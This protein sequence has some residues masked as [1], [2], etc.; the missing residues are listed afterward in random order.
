MTIQ[1]KSKLFLISVAANALMLIMLCGI[2]YYKRASFVRLYDK[3]FAKSQVNEQELKAFNT[4][5][6]DG[7]SNY[8][9]VEG[10]G[11]LKYSF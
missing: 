7:V 2:G 10:G 4:V 3:H 9:T 8:Y 11:S 1:N 5:K 6:Y